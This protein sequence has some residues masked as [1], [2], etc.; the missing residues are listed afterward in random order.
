[1]SEPSQPPP[2]EESG[3]SRRSLLRRAGT[4]AAA[5]GAAGAIAGCENTTTPV[6]AGSGGGGGGKGLLGDPTAGGPVDASGIPL[7]RRDYPVT[8]PRIGDPV[9]SSTQGE[10]G[11]ELKIYNYADYLD[12]AVAKAFGKREGVSVR[13]TT[14]QTLEEAFSKLSAGGLEVDVI[15]ST[16]DQLS[17]LVGRQLVQPLNHELVPNAHK[18]IWPE[19]YSPFYDV[20]A[21]Y[22]VPYVTYTTGIGWRRDK[23]DIDPSKL[24]QPWDALWDAGRYSGRVGIL[25]DKREGIGM[26]LMRR[27]VTDLNTE[28][29]DLIA[30]AG[31][32]LK[33]LD[34]NVRVKVSIS[35][36]ETLP[37][38]RMWMHQ[39]WSGDLINAVIS[40]LPKGTKPSVLGYWYQAQGGPI[41]NDIICVSAKA[42][43]PVLAHRFL[44][45]M[46]DEKVAYQNF[47]GYVGYQPPIT[48]IDPQALLDDGVI[49]S[50]LKDVIVTRDAYANGNAY[51]TLTAAG[52]RLWDKTWNSFRSG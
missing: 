18:T 13:V 42:A 28:D 19:L 26:A 17:R 45:Y 21:R 22:S 5:A 23:V 11:G 16:P 38:G 20:D 1:M 43:K 35:E 24:D 48:A 27:G 50:T 47:T 6:Q 44:N 31:E 2:G 34:R 25:D 9:S 46:L 14:F 49:P 33:E 30:R 8:L 7:A 37:A 4:L 12:P 40:Y 36:Y 15:F 10:H 51:L 39:A 41:F 32:D 52:E 3:L 29:A